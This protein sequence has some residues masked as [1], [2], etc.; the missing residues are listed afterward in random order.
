MPR[1]RALARCYTTTMTPLYISVGQWLYTTKSYWY[2]HEC[3]LIGL[4]KV[5]R[6]WRPYI[7]GRSFTIHTDQYS[8]KFLLNQR[9]STWV[10]KL[11]GYDFMVKY[12]PD[13]LNGDADALSRWGGDVAAALD[14][15]SPTFELFDTLRDEATSNSQVVDM[16]SKLAAKTA[17]T[18]WIEAD[19][20]PLF[21]GKIF[22]PDGSSLWPELL[23]FAHDSGHED[24]KNTL[25]RFRASFYNQ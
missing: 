7:W 8:L 14:L 20:L 17:P 18:G 15:S 16:R 10:S 11:L 3:E 13:K 23:S 22:I 21:Q 5:V 2:M 9:L 12:R 25:Q 4:V 6:H 24:M 19:G 1:A